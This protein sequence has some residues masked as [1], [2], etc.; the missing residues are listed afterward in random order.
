LEQRLVALA[1]VQKRVSWPIPDGDYQ[2]FIRP[3][4]NQRR[5][6]ALRVRLRR[7]H[8]AAPESQ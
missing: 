8:D 6:K 7:E 2:R 4:E 1:D 3:Y 5:L